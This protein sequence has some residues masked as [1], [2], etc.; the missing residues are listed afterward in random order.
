MY[1]KLYINDWRKIIDNELVNNDN[2]ISNIFD[3][4]KDLVINSSNKVYCG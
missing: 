2:E 3:N 1:M 4:I